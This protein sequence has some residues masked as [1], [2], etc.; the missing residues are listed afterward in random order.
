MTIIKNICIAMFFL[1]MRSSQNNKMADDWRNCI[2]IPV[3]KSS[4]Q[5]KIMHIG[6]W[7]APWYVH[8]NKHVYTTHV[9]YENTYQSS[10]FDT[11]IK[12]DQ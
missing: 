4:P 2:V 11:I 3:K 6:R 7:R 12:K 10:D 5:F 9:H 8:V 1:R